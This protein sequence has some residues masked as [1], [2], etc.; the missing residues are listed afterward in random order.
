MTVWS[1]VVL[2]GAVTSAVISVSGALYARAQ[3][4][5]TKASLEAII[6]LTVRP[7]KTEKETLADW[8]AEHPHRPHKDDPPAGGTRGGWH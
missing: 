7:P 8:L 1:W 3:Y 6:A 2:I 5:K 4:D